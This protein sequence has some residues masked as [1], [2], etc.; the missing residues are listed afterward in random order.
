MLVTWE[1]YGC[2]QAY[3]GMCLYISRPGG[4]ILASRALRLDGP[5]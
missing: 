5:G 3:L 4:Q 1:G 2:M